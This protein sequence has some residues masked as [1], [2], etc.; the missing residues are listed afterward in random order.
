MKQLN[1]TPALPESLVKQ[2][3]GQAEMT[4]AFWRGS[5]DP[6]EVELRQLRLYEA[7]LMERAATALERQIADLAECYRMTGADPDS[8]EDWRLAGEAV[9]AVAE[10][11]ELYDELTIGL[12]EDE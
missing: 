2:L 9:Q 8:N 5:C 1:T 4:R 6:D 11:R 3:R 12:T 10:L 7:D